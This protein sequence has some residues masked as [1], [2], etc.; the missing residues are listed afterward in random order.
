MPAA[1]DSNTR[2]PMTL[3]HTINFGDLELADDK[4]I[5]FKEGIPGFPQIHRFTLL[6][7]D[8]LKPFQYLQALD[9]PPIALLVINPFLVDPGYQFQLTESDMDDIQTRETHDVSVY[10]VATIP[11]NADEATLNLMAPIVVNASQKQGK[12]VVLH[13]SGYS[14]KHPLFSPS[15]QTGSKHG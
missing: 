11:E 5:T 12:Q 14:V 10:A 2:D 6:E 9:D 1:S 7:K 4:I 8:E 3:I 15:E 13:Q